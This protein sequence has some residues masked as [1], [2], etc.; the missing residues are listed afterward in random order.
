VDRFLVGHRPANPFG[1]VDLMGGDNVTRPP[2]FCST[3]TAAATN[4][5]LES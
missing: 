5:T 4:A 2:L 3:W 1:G